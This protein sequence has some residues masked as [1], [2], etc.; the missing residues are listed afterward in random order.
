MLQTERPL[1]LLQELPGA[2]GIEVW[3]IQECRPGLSL[4]V[5]LRCEQSDQVADIVLAVGQRI[6]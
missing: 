3:D 1:N 4:I 5:P 6:E 2:E